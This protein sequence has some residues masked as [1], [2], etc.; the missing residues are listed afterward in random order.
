[1]PLHTVEAFILRTYPLKESDK[2]VSF[3][4]RELGKCRGVA[5]GARRP[6]SKFGSSLEPLSQVR[7]QFF[8]R[9]GRDLVNLDHAD[10]LAPSP[11]LALAGASGDL[12]HSMAVPVMVEVADRMLPER[13][14][15]DS[16]YRL[17]LHAVP[18]LG[19]AVAA[20][21]WLPLTYYLYWMVR[22]GG[23]LP[24]LADLGAASQELAARLARSTLAELGPERAE[25]AAGAPGRLL[26]Q[27]L[28]W[29][30]EDH[31]EARLAA[32][33]MLASL[34]A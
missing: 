7:V 31:V 10:L 6:K 28:K 19:A 33:P 34:D 17:L 1:M 9:E 5:R 4:T 11:Q 24:N 15:S 32:W 30:I 18:A 23:F 16:V 14:A 25:E 20:G 8:E 22:L 12:L 26:R 21:V 13:E 29:C 2:I 3:F 27:K